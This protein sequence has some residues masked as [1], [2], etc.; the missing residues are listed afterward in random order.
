[1]LLTK[2]EKA[3]PITFSPIAEKTLQKNLPAALW[4]EGFFGRLGVQRSQLFK[5][6]SLRGK[7]KARI[8]PECGTAMLLVTL[9]TGFFPDFL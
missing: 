6:L 4:P 1:M 7:S 8:A 9:T 5:G 3:Q 2:D